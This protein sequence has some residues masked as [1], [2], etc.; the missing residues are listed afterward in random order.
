MRASLARRSPCERAVVREPG[1]EAQ[2][3][4]LAQVR[5]GDALRYAGS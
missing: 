4:G 2:E 3:L 5:A 1:P